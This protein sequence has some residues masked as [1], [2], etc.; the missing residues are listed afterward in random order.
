LRS[1][2]GDRVDLRPR[3]YVRSWR[4]FHAL[5]GLGKIG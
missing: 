5:F 3:S 1:T 2:T 4:K